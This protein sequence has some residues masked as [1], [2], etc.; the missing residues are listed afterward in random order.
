MT[1]RRVAP[2]KW[3]LVG[4]QWEKKEDWRTI[5]GPHVP[6][7][8]KPRWW[9]APK[10]SSFQGG[11]LNCPPRP[12]QLP[13]DAYLGVG[14]GMV[15]VLKDGVPIWSGDSENRTVRQYELLAAADPDHDWRIEYIGP[16]SESTYQRHGREEWNL[17]QT[18]PGFA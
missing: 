18:G 6:V 8:G 17:I 5:Y 7:K 12:D 3:R 9:I 2:P 11:C 14:F 15:G 4:N 16:M 10:G 1:K 13:M